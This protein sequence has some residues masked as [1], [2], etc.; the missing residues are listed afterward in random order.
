MKQEKIILHVRF[1]SDRKRGTTKADT[2]RQ[3]QEG[4]TISNSHIKK[5]SHNCGYAEN[6]NKTNQTNQ[7]QQG[8]LSVSFFVQGYINQNMCK[9]K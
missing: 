1:N 2:G 8:V 5:Q 6:K 7:Q 4:R 9:D 3:I